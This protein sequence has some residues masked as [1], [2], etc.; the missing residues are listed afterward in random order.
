MV[1]GGAAF[2]AAF[3]Y[4]AAFGRML[5]E[6]GS[7]A[8]DADRQ[9]AW[10]VPFELGKHLVLAVIVAGIAVNADIGGWMGG[11]VLGLALWVGFPV[12]LLASSV[13]HEKVPG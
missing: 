10:L 4:Y 6:L 9:P 5:G 1:A 13:V 8:A 7:A 11:V 3:A 2:V 12:V